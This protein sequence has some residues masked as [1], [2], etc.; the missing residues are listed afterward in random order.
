M[1]EAVVEHNNKKQ[2]MLQQSIHK[3]YMYTIKYI[4]YWDVT[5]V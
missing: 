4:K 3:A 1:N 2:K 5:Q